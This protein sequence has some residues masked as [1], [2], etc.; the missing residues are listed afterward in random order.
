MVF[1][2]ARELGKFPE[3][4]EAHLTPQRLWEW[5]AFFKWDKEQLDAL[6]AKR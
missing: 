4:V 6:R 5:E 3:E 2:L 1:Q